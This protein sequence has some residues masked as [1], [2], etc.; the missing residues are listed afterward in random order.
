[1]RETEK[2]FKKMGGGAPYYEKAAR[3]FKEPIA[4]IVSFNGEDVLLTSGNGFNGQH[5]YDPNATWQG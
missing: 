2:T 1:M 5:N 4:E 3:E